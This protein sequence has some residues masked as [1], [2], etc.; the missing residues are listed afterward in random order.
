MQLRM[1]MTSGISCY[2]IVNVPI[3]HHNM[4]VMTKSDRDQMLY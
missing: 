2:G 1:S 4:E 3:L